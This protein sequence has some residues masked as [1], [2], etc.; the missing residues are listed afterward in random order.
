MLL[1]VNLVTGEKIDNRQVLV[2]KAVPAVT[3]STLTTAAGPPQPRQVDY[4]DVPIM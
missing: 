2:N 3:I 4:R 1:T